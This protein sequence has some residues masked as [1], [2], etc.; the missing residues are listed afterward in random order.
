MCRD[1]FH[2]SRNP[3]CVE[4]E[5]S[6][7]SVLGKPRDTLMCPCVGAAPGSDADG[8]NVGKS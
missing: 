8:Q 1:R 6:L 3:P 2:S 5:T 7:P 4:S